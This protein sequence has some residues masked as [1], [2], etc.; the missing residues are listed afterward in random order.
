MADQRDQ[1]KAFGTREKLLLTRGAS[2]YRLQ[3]LA[4]TDLSSEAVLMA[5]RPYAKCGYRREVA[6]GWGGAA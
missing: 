3:R 5:V 2:W 1:E 6:G 4:I